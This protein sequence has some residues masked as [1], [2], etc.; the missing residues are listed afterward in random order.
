MLLVVTGAHGFLGSDIVRQAIG[1]GVPVRATDRDVNRCIADAEYVRADILDPP[2]LK[3]VLRGATAVIHA[4]GLAHIFDA[5][6]AAG[7]PFKA[8][9]EIGTANVVQ[10]AVG[11]GVRHF[12][13]VS[14][15]SVYGDGSKGSCDETTPCNPM[16]AYAQSKWHAEKRA[17]ELASGAGTALTILRMATI[18][19]EGDP[20]NV[21]RLIRTIDRG[22][23][24]WIG[25]GANRKSL[26][27]R[28][29]AAR[30][31]VVAARRP[32]SGVRIFNVA[33]PPCTMRQ[34]VEEIATALGRPIPRWRVP[35]ALAL[36]AARLAAQLARG[37]GRFGMLHGTVQKWL[38]DDVYDASRFWQSYDFRTKVDLAHGIRREVAWYQSGAG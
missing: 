3:P 12:V 1:S 8:V 2:S 28:E 36:H 30:A 13:L 20:G 24:I 7:A 38:A 34:V 19:G 6:E 15:V 29:D 4:A 16:G 35:A 21:A 31:C 23:F 32:G 37:H 11:A 5:S 14:S 25:S 9:N 18:Y 17:I 10:A 27:H 33:A 26:I 22:R